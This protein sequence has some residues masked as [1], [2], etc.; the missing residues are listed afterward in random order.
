MVIRNK[1]VLEKDRI[2]DDLQQKLKFKD[3]D[4]DLL[5]RKNI[6]LKQAL[7]DLEERH[8]K[9]EEEMS[10]FD[11]VKR[12]LESEKADIIEQKEFIEQKYQKELTEL[13]AVN[14][15]AAAALEMLTLFQS[16]SSNNKEG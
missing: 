5:Y 2:I 10:K 13:Q 15:Q 1:E 11:L 6:Q 9:L 14:S 7:S 8:K 3:E 16:P 4:L 12:G